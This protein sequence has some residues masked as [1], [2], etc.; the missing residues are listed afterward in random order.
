MDCEETKGVSY[1]TNEKELKEK[2]ENE[3]YLV[4]HTKPCP[5]CQSPTEKNDGCAHMTCK[6]C[7]H[8]YCWIC[9]GDWT[10]HT[11]N[12]N[13]NKGQNIQA[14][15][16][17]KNASVIED[18]KDK[19]LMIN[20]LNNFDG[21]KHMEQAKQDLLDYNSKLNSIDYNDLKEY[22]KTNPDE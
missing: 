10:G 16:N 14:E 1:N 3:K 12:Y 21:A 11:D 13:C 8:Q 4:D 22:H 5:K 17:L 9:L 20:T 18:I 19:L 7:Q 2:L 6:K 15:R